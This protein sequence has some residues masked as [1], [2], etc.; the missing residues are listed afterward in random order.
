MKLTVRK[1]AIARTRMLFEQRQASAVEAEEKGALRDALPISGIRLYLAQADLK[2]PF[3]VI[4]FVSISLGSLF[5]LLL[6]L[7]LSPYFLPLFFLAGAALPWIWCEL[8]VVKRASDFSAEYPTVLLATAASI[9]SGM[10]ACAALERAVRLLP[11]ESLA[12]T[13]V[14][15]LMKALNEGVPRAEALAAFG[16]TVRQPDLQLFRTA[17]LLVLENGGRF[18]PTLERLAAV[19]RDRSILIREARVSTAT[20]RMTANVL[21]GMAPL[22]LAMIS[23]RLPNFWDIF[24]HNAVANT[25]ASIGIV[26]ITAS[27]AVLWKMSA[28]RP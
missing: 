17:F 2:I 16:R 10:T 9:K 21:L 3:A 1:K 7:F 15:T 25:M 13:E 26:V 14:N 22:I 4:L 12:A 11:K 28:F 19:C 6:S 18:A 8:R 20:M 5:A 27:F 23:A 24:C